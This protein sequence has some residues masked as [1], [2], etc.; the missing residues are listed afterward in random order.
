MR[1]RHL[2]LVE[3]IDREVRGPR[4]STGGE[5]GRMNEQSYDP[6]VPVKVGNRRAPQGAAT[7]PTGG[8]GE[9]TVRICRKET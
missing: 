5:R 7:E 9:T 8:K 4:G 6:I 1:A 3:T 2:R